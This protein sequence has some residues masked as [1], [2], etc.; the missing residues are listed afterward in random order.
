MHCCNFKVK[1]LWEKQWR[2]PPALDEILIMYDVCWLITYESL[3]GGVDEVL[4]LG[5][6]TISSRPP[7]IIVAMVTGAVD[8]A[9]CA[10]LVS[11][12]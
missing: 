9:F 2:C 11:V 5:I 4:P 7:I 10:P 1:C 6:A 12:V 3:V 8:D